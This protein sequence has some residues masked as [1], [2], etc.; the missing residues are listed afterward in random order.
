ME[1]KVPTLQTYNSHTFPD[2]L[3]SV[4]R[5]AE[6]PPGIPE[7]PHLPVVAQ[8]FGH[9]Q[10]LSQLTPSLHLSARSDS[11]SFPFGR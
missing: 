7:Q 8:E 1:P 11:A 4:P 10:Q 2:L 9:I 5:K 6:E 3:S